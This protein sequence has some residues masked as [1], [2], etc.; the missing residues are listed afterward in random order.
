MW[1]SKIHTFF[2]QHGFDHSTQDYSLYI[3]YD[4]RILALVYVDDLVL[5]AAD[6]GAIGWI[7]GELTNSFEMTDLGELTAFLGLEIKRVRSQRLITLS[8]HQY[9]Q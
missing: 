8:Q 9:I 2:A 3:N 4:R 5:A 6:R 7:K 1:Y